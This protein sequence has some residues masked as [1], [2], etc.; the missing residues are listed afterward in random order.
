MN[1]VFL[2]GYI[3]SDVELKTTAQGTSVVTFQLAV[4]RPKTK[5]DTT[6]FITI[7]CWRSTAE[8]VSKYFR[9]GSGIEISGIITVRKWQDK[10]GNNRYSTEIVANEVDFG[11]KSKDDDQQGQ[12]YSQPQYTPPQNAEFEEIGDDDDL[13]F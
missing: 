2:T 1:K 3:A 7:V 6:D 4:K 10:D 13:P 11:K 5:N 8:F 9:K 12:S